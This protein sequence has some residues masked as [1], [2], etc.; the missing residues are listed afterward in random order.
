MY[1]FIAC[2]KD[3]VLQK[4]GSFPTRRSSDLL[5]VAGNVG[6][7]TTTVSAK[8]HSLATTEQLRLGYDASNYNS[9]TVGS[10]GS[11]TLAATG[12]NPNITLTPGGT[13]YTILNG[14]VGIGTTGPGY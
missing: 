10:T 2:C 13:G 4:I 8:L 12:T 9:F 3:I 5:I 6:I 11:L 1:M 14:N 7:G